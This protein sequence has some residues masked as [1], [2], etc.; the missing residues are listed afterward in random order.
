VQQTSAH[1]LWQVEDLEE[2]HTTTLVPEVEAQED[3]LNKQ[4]AC[5]RVLQYLQLSAKEPDQ[6]LDPT[7]MGLMVKIPSSHH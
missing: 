4:S 5:L 6:A 1:W 7:Q 2:I 3:T